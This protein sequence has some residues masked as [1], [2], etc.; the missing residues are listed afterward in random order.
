MTVTVQGKR[1]AQ[2]LNETLHAIFAAHDDVVLFGEDVL[3]PY[4]G[5]FKV[6]AGLSDAYPDRVLTI[7]KTMGALPDRVRIVGC[8]P[9]EV[10]ELGQWLSPVVDAAADRAVVVV[11]KLVSAWLQEPAGAG[12]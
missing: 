8:Q 5:A 10:D 11:R 12:L 6:T 3:D 9:S 1:G 2:V 7:A 4:G